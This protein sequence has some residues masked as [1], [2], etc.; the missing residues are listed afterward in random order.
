MYSFKQCVPMALSES[1]GN[2]AS[3]KVGQWIGVNRRHRGE[4]CVTQME[5]NTAGICGVLTGFLPSVPSCSLPHS[6]C[7]SCIVSPFFYYIDEIDSF[8]LIPSPTVGT[9]GAFLEKIPFS[10]FSSFQ[11]WNFLKR[12]PSHLPPKRESS[13]WPP[14]CFSLVSLYHNRFG[15]LFKVLE[16]SGRNICAPTLQVVSWMGN[17]A[18]KDAMS[19]SQAG[20]PA[21][22]DL[23]LVS[24]SFPAYQ[25]SC[26][27]P[28][29]VADGNSCL[30]QEWLVAFSPGFLPNKFLSNL[31]YT[32]PSCCWKKFLPKVLFALLWL[33][34]GHFY[35]PLDYAYNSTICITSAVFS[36]C[37]K[38]SSNWSFSFIACGQFEGTWAC[39]DVDHCVAQNVRISRRRK[40]LFFFFFF[41]IFVIFPSLNRAA[42][43]KCWI[44]NFW[45]EDLFF[46]PFYPSSLHLPFYIWG[47]CFLFLYFQVLN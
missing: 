27:P 16:F 26:Y 25:P 39:G 5:K 14:S 23:V 12:I 29:Q 10:V 3:T 45:V 11:T 19:S 9:L 18:G 34:F 37:F 31:S 20:S 30:S 7:L 8:L 28:S 38:V 1:D 13:S 41:R 43:S 21:P 36:C 47:Q 24:E 2:T 44:Y 4:V 17:L 33:A 15:Q 22:F 32:G 46:F 6:F 40:G 35:I 42:Q